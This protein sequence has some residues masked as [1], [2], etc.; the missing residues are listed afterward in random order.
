MMWFPSRRNRDHLQ[1]SEG[2]AAVAPEDAGNKPIGRIEEL[3]RRVSRRDSGLSPIELS[4]S[5]KNLHDYVRKI[6]AED[7][8]SY[9]RGDDRHSLPP[10]ARNIGYAKP[11][12]QAFGVSDPGAEILVEHWMKHLGERSA[13]VTRYTNDGGIDVFSENYV[14]Q[15]KNYSGAVEIE[16]VRALA[17]VAAHCDRRALFFTSGRF[18]ARSIVFADEMRMGLFVYDARGGNLLARNAV[19]DF[20]IRNGL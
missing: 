5:D 10:T 4:D 17:G 8:P 16:A 20:Y 18:S 19:A 6:V 13:H 14:A 2:S 12:P 1:G 9:G 15:V 11:L 3:R 7:T